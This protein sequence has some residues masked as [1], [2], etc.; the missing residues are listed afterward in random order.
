MSEDCLY[1]LSCYLIQFITMLFLISRSKNK[2]KAGIINISVFAIYNVIFHYNLTYNSSGG[3]G[4]VWF[5]YLMLS[6]GIHWLI[7]TAG[8]IRTFIVK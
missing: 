6:L 1:L 3:S 2:M 4:L 7:N 5:I 8:I